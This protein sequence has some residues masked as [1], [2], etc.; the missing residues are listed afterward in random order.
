MTRKPVVGVV[1]HGYRVPKPFGDLPVTGTPPT[2]V[3]AITAAGGRPL[4]LPPRHAPEL[5]DLVDALVLTGGG[6]VDPA[7]YGGSGPAEDVDPQRDEEEIAVVHAA[8]ADRVPLLGVCRGMQIL[9]VAFGGTLRGGLEHRLPVD[10]HE[11]RT[12]PGSLIA[13]LLGP[14]AQT[15]ALHR[16]AVLDPG[17]SWTA[18]AWSHD[19]TTEALEPTTTGWS[20][21]GVQWHPELH[22]HELLTDPTG[23]ALFGWLVGQA[24][25]LTA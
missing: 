9:A 10:G 6:D 20:V 2:Y 16:Q 13:D 19:G 21:L 1:G 24:R 18:T 7:R 25:V 3:D 15:S 11:V 12:A 22:A 4:I 23:P 5:L 8:A 17:P 14:V